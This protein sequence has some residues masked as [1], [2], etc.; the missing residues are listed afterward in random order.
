VIVNYFNLIRAIESPSEAYPISIIDVD[1]LLALTITYKELR[2][3]AW[4]NTQ[5]V[6][7]FS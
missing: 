1:T 4:R 2:S 3:S 7:V 5:V 6:Q